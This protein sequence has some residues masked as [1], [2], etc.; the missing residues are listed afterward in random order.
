M[1]RNRP[2]EKTAAGNPAEEG[3]RQ[4]EGEGFTG[5]RGDGEGRDGIRGSIRLARGWLLRVASMQG[6]WCRGG[7]LSCGTG[8]TGHHRRRDVPSV[9]SRHGVR[10]C[11]SAVRR[12][13]PGALD[14]GGGEPRCTLQGLARTDPTAF[15]SPRPPVPYLHSYHYI[16]ARPASVAQIDIA[17]S[18]GAYGPGSGQS[19]ASALLLWSP[20]SR[21]PASPPPCEPSLPLFLFLSFTQHRLN[22]HPDAPGSAVRPVNGYDRSRWP[23]GISR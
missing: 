2:A 5:R 11:T 6:C 21:L 8:R 4:R 17:G 7:R 12:Q 1:E 15:P 19:Y 9:E 3:E 20:I 16:D 22:C 23:E 13:T 18:P 10:A 14:R